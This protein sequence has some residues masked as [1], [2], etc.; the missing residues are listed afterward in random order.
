MKNFRNLSVTLAVSGV[1][2][3]LACVGE[4]EASMLAWERG[5]IVHGELWRLWSCHLVHFSASHARADTLALFAMGLYAEPL[6]GSRRFALLLA[7]AAALLSL[8]MLALAPGLNEY[9][10]ASGLATLTAVLAGVLA[11]RRHPASRPVLACA[12]LA[13]AAKTLWEAGAHAAAFAELPAGVAVAW[14]AHLMGVLLGALAAAWF[15]GRLRWPLT[16]PLS[17][18]W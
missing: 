14:Q 4:S 3:L 1:C 9:R 2:V 11:W 12:A 16:K 15:D 6:V 13:L 10:G 17:V 18:L 5:A 8:G 7:G